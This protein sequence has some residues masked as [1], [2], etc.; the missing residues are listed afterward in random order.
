M[1][2][3]VQLNTEGHLIGTL[4]RLLETKRQLSSPMGKVGKSQIVNEKRNRNINNCRLH[5][6]ISQKDHISVT[7]SCSSHG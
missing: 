1:V 4:P 3:P 2:G 7:Q 5:S 6:P